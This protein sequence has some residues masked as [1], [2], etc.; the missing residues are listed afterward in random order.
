MKFQIYLGKTLS[1]LCS[2]LA[3]HRAET[4]SRQQAA[5][6]LARTR[7]EK[8]RDSCYCDC[9]QIKSKYFSSPS[10]SQNFQDTQS[11]D[12]NDDNHYYHK[13]LV[14]DCAC[15]CHGTYNQNDLF[16]DLDDEIHKKSERL[17]TPKFTN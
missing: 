17:L 6:E 10:K 13:N 14:K 15:V 5:Q 9:D 3:W 7:L 12:C 11:S 4:Q 1:L 2:V 8:L 16:N